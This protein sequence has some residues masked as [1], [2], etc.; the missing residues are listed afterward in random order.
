MQF[1]D[2]WQLNIDEIDMYG[3]PICGIIK[4]YTESLTKVEFREISIEIISRNLGFTEIFCEIL[5]SR[6][7]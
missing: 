6:N 4:L 5:V 7:V 2:F 3:R 1:L